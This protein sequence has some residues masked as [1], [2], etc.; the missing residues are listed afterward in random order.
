MSRTYKDRPYWVR[1]NDK[2]EVR[3]ADHMHHTPMFYRPDSNF[4]GEIGVCDIDKPMTGS[5]KIDRKRN[6]DYRLPNVRWWDRPR[7]FYRNSHYYA[8]VRLIE[9]DT[10][11][12]SAKQYNTMG[13]VDDVDLPQQHRH[14][15]YGG[16]YWD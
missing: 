6:C 2:S 14:S 16:G 12:K 5:Y 8:P 13:E 3:V 1:Q 7:R 15:P 10:L 11:D 9:R 4:W